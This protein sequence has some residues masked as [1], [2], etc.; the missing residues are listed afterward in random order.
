MTVGRFDVG[1]SGC[2]YRWWC[3]GPGFGIT[4]LD[5][6]WIRLFLKGETSAMARARTPNGIVIIYVKALVS[7]VVGLSGFFCHA[8]ALQAA[9]HDT[10]KC[11]RILQQKHHR[12]K[13]T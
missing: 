1:A 11:F 2:L 8:F 13:S 7:K 4:I 5:V 12:P 10:S 9:R 6:V 3:A